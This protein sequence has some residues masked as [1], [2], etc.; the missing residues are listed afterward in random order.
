MHCVM[1]FKVSIKGHRAP[2]S[3]APIVVMAPHSTFYDTLAH[4]VIGTPSVVAK[5]SLFSVPIVGS[6]HIM[7]LK[8]YIDGH[9]KKFL[10]TVTRQKHEKIINLI[11]IN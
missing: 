3:L 1:G 11:I 6:N 2:A 4:C 9:A 8:K 5:K 10:L 7:N